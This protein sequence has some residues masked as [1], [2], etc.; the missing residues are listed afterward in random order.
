MKTAEKR[1][2][3]T[4]PYRVTRDGKTLFRSHDRALARAYYHGQPPLKARLMHG[5]RD[6]SPKV[7]RESLPEPQLAD[8]TESLAGI[9]SVGE[10]FALEIVPAADDRRFLE[11]GL[12]CDDPL[13]K[14]DRNAFDSC[15]DGIEGIR[16]L[17]ADVILEIRQEEET[18]FRWLK[19]T[20]GR[21]EYEH[22]SQPTAG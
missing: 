21:E 4:P 18:F 11:V 12:I 20:N 16:Q 9:W 2:K 17:L 14:L 7:D 10:Q 8:L 15:C 22:R 3:K 6:I 1:Q 13:V 19:A 5:K